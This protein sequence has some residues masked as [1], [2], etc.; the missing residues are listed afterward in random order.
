M[1]AKEIGDHGEEGDTQIEIV[2]H[3]QGDVVEQWMDGDD[4]IGA[5]A[6]NQLGQPLPDEGLREAPG[7]VEAVDAI[8]H[9]KQL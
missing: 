7:G 8:C 6:L 5:R 4:D 1:D 2:E 3:L 9:A